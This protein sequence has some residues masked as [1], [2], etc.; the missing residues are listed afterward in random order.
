MLVKKSVKKS[1]VLFPWKANFDLCGGGLGNVI[2]AIKPNSYRY[3]LQVRIFL[4]LE[5][6]FRDLGIQ[7]ELG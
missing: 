5:R 6:S 4:N 7:H 2:L 1:I 3:G